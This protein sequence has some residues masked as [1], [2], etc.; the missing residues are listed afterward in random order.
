MTRHRPI[1]SK[2]STTSKV[3]GTPRAHSSMYTIAPSPLR[4][5]IGRAVVCVHARSLL[6]VKDSHRHVVCQIARGPAIEYAAR[7][8]ATIRDGTPWPPGVTAL[9]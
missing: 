8:E 6:P 5:P 7:Q 9:R 3:N 2:K 4:A 1:P